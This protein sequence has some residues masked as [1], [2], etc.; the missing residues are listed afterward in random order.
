[1]LIMVPFAGL[2]KAGLMRPYSLP[3]GGTILLLAVST[4]LM[5]TLS[6]MLAAAWTVGRVCTAPI[7]RLL[8][9]D[10]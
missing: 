6:G 9:E 2:M 4:L 10:G 7:S 3:D 5:A 8:R 1:A